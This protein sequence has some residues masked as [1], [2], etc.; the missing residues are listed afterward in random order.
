M[1]ST[2]VTRLRQCKDLGRRR[3]CY[4]FYVGCLGVGTIWA[5]SDEDAL[6]IAY[7]RWPDVSLTFRV[8]E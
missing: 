1:K 5:A 8:L 7:Q 2:T 3:R 4:F 6:E